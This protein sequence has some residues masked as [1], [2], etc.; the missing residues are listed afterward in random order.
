MLFPLLLGTCALFFLLLLDALSLLP[1]ALLVFLQL[2]FARF[3]A[4]L[5]HFLMSSLPSLL[6]FLLS[7]LSLLLLGLLGPLP[8]TLL[9]PFLF[10][11]GFPLLAANI[12]LLLPLL[13]CLAPA[14]LLLSCHFGADLLY[15]VFAH[16]GQ[17]LLLDQ[18][19]EQCIDRLRDFSIDVAALTS[20]F[21][22]RC[23]DSGVFG[24]QGRVAVGFAVD[25]L[26]KRGEEVSFGGL[27]VY[28]RSCHRLLCTIALRTLASNCASRSLR[29][30][31]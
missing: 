31:S 22:Q 20:A 5:L 16:P 24:Q 28:I 19:V 10:V 25:E 7:A 15:A 9:L 13:F 11:L 29:M 23:G 27:H 8:F 17:A 1:P 3:A 6:F 30:L 12:S 21:D 2:C 4:F 14:L 18:V 26:F